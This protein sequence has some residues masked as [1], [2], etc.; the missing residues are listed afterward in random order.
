[1]EILNYLRGHCGATWDYV[2]EGRSFVLARI[3]VA[4]NDSLT[5]ESLASEE[6]RGA[7]AEYA[8]R[9][10][11]KCTDIEPHERF[12]KWLRGQVGKLSV[13]WVNIMKPYREFVDSMDDMTPQQCFEDH[14]RG[15]LSTLAMCYMAGVPANLTDA[16]ELLKE[17]K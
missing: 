15:V 13:H 14:F 6:W 8:S 3:I 16:I 4:I 17:N 12:R 2:P 7:L 10:T 1:M 11:D 9:D 5:P